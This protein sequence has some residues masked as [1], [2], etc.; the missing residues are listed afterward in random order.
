LS[1]LDH[2]RYHEVERLFAAWPVLEGILE[3]LN[4]DIKAAR[5]RESIGTDEEY[6]YDLSI[7]NKVPDGMP[8]ARELGDTTGNIAASYSSIMRHELENVRRELKEECM[9]IASVL[10]K[11]TIAFRRLSP[12]QRSILELY[13]WE[14]K[15][16]K[17]IL[18]EK[19]YTSKAQAQRYRKTGIEKIRVIAKVTIEDYKAVMK[20][21][22]KEAVRKDEQKHS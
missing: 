11:L 14:K 9:V 2:I 13:Y 17:E 6:I 4:V 1:S 7:G 15:T 3:S 16:W 19:Q 20:L 12:L 10:D 22:G 21:A 18:A 8:K 5:A